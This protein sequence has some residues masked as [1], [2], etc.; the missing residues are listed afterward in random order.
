MENNTLADIKDTD[1]LVL[2]SKKIAFSLK[3]KKTAHTQLL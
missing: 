3:K 2:V 1:F